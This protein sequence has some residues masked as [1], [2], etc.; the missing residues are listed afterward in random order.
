VAGKRL[1]FRPLTGMTYAQ[2]PASVQSP[3]CCPQD[4]TTVKRFHALRA[5]PDGAADSLLDRLSQSPAR[6]VIEVL[7]V[8][9]FSVVG[10]VDGRFM[11]I[12]H[13]R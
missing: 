4:D 10:E 11:D 9:E 5:E 2:I 3:L 13:V 8:A 7:V 6:G 12:H 1:L